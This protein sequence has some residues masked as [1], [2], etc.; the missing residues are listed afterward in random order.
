MLFYESFHHNYQEVRMEW[1][2]S[3]ILLLK[4]NITLPDYVLIGYKA[5][6]VKR[7]RVHIPL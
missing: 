2:Q 6:S 5:E 4:E 7:V 1:T 3:P